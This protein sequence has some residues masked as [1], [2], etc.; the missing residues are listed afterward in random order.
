MKLSVHRGTTWQ[1]SGYVKGGDEWHVGS[2]RAK[3][4]ARKQETNESKTPGVLLCGVRSPLQSVSTPCTDTPLLLVRAYPRRCR[5][6]CL[7]MCGV[8][9]WN[10]PKLA[11]S[12]ASPC[13]SRKRV[14][15]SSPVQHAGRSFTA[16]DAAPQK[17]I[18]LRVAWSC[19]STPPAPPRNTRLLF[20]LM[21]EIVLI[22]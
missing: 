14:L 11:P 20:F 2:R 4:Q 3:Q 8:A 9:A 18:F 7:D 16:R 1:D 10:V 22:K 6:W 21:F 19:E 17:E 12:L 5:C 13:G 15:I